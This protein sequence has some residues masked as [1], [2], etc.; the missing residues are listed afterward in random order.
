MKTFQ[1]LT[2]LQWIKIAIATAVFIVP[3]EYKIIGLI[4]MIGIVIYEMFTV[5]PEER[6][7]R[8]KSMAITF[9][10][11]LAMVAITLYASSRIHS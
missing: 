6:K 7:H 5:T 3:Y 1:A 8:L 9:A 10:V 11:M 4:L 2:P